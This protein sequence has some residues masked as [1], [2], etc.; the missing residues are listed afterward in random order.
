MTIAGLKIERAKWQCNF[1]VFA[2][3]LK[4]PRLNALL[5]SLNVVNDACKRL[6]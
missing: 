1:R 4:N 5:F 3:L 2:L 6:S